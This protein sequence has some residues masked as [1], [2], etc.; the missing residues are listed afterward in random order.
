MALFANSNV[1]Y[2]QEM[3]KVGAAGCLTRAC[4][5]SD[6]VLAIR[7]VMKQ[8]VYLSPRI[9]E[10]VV[11]GYVLPGGG[12]A[13]LSTREREILQRIAAG[14]TTK[15]IAAA[16]SV[17]TKTIETHRRRMMEKLGLHSIAEL[18][19]YAVQQGLTSLELQI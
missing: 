12:K 4:A 19:K 7:T 8:Q 18:T 1:G 9:A 2:V 17:S 14:E 10:A 13:S 5:A 11:N 3:L 16:F 6:L 15:Q